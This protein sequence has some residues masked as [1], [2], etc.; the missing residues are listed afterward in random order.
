MTLTT[1]N[2]KIKG[3]LPYPPENAVI[4]IYNFLCHENN[5]ERC[6]D[7]WILDFHTGEIKFPMKKLNQTPAFWYGTNTSGETNNIKGTNIFWKIE[8][9]M[10][11]FWLKE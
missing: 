6:E 11:V 10:F 1:I 2:S 9:D 8:D 3:N 7:G 4:I 5:G